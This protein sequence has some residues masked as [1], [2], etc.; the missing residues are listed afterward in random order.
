[1]TVYDYTVR[2]M[3]GENKP[4]TDY[5]GKVLLIVNT[6]TKCG[7]SK[8]LKDLQALY[9]TYQ[10]SNFTVLGFPCNQFKNQEP[11]TNE[12]TKTACQKKFG[13]TFPLFQKID[14]KG[15]RTHPLF[16]YLTSKTQGMMTN[17]IKWNF[18]KFLVDRKGDV[19]KRY[20]P[21]TSPKKIASD[22]EKL[23]N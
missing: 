16:K 14:V 1:M 12:E 7:F 3:N 10:D 17:Q 6:A 13:V 21:I 9:E 18:T 20:A 4:F 23:L 11:G 15:S 8:Q 5:N 19:I 2:L 22:I